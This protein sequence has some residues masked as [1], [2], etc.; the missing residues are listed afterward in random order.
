MRSNIEK[1]RQVFQHRFGT[2]K[3]GQKKLS[4]FSVSLTKLMSFYGGLIRPFKP[5]L[6]Q[7]FLAQLKKNLGAIEEFSLILLKKLVL[8][9][10]IY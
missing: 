4:S 3:C 7:S 9:R 8:S 6:Y 10:C 1:K 5:G 2:V